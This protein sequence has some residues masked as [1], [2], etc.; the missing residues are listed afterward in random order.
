VPFLELFGWQ[1]R[2]VASGKPALLA[3]T[4]LDGSGIG[5]TE[6]KGLN[7]LRSALDKGAHRSDRAM[8]HV[9]RLV[10]AMPAI[11]G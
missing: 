4:A 2:R 9:R 3:W 7:W 8:G 6:R 11:L 10:T 5:V 1:G